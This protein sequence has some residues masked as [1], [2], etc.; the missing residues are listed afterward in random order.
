MHI[1]H[2]FTI[3]H[4]SQFLHNEIVDYT[5]IDCFSQNRDEIVLHFHKNEVSK[6]LVLNV[7]SVFPFYYLTANFS[8][9]HKNTATIF[10]D[11]FHLNVLSVRILEGERILIIHLENDH[12]VVLKLFGKLSNVLHYFNG[13]VL[14]IFRNSLDDDFGWQP[15]P[16]PN[17]QLFLSYLN[18]EELTFDE[19]L[20][21]PYW[22]KFFKN[23]ILTYREKG[24]SAIEIAIN[25]YEIFLNPRF[26]VSRNLEFQ[27]F[28]IHDSE[29]FIFDDLNEALN[30]FV[31]FFYID[32]QFKVKKNQIQKQIDSQIKNL[33]NKIRSNEISIQNLLNSRSYE[34]IAN[35]LMANL[36]LD[37]K[38]LDRYIF[39][40]FYL[41]GKIEI[42]LK[43]E[44]SLQQNAE[45]YYQKHK[46]RKK[47]LLS[48]E[49]LFSENQSKLN[50]LLQLKNE[51]DSITSLKTLD[52]WLKQYPQFLGQMNINSMVS[53]P[54]KEFIIQGFKIWVGKDAK[55]NDQLTLHYAH[56]NDIWLHAKDVSGS[57]V[58]IKTQN[59]K[60]IPKEIIVHAAE[61]AG[62]YSKNRNQN[63]IP[64]IY[65]E[66]KYVRKGKGL[67][68]GKV[69]VERENIV[70]VS[71]KSYEQIV[72]L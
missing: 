29:F 48:L 63:Y 45:L 42:S 46:K 67:P 23:Y 9:S 41:S 33:Q 49:V 8:K 57:H 12:Q 58:L 10:E 40:D 61:L 55:S 27:L 70:F 30:R 17:F 35:I 44:L 19:L 2:Y 1:F 15:H 3:H 28:P 24:Y 18:N 34:E 22:D 6:F 59:H 72:S 68:P 69:I 50:N 64:V 20:Q 11:I 52:K 53:L 62:Y 38:N 5:L 31:K 21:L 66:K 36:H 39:D 47:E 25:L 56:K 37:V 13:Q 43:K 71:P 65:T 4:F 32:Y 16:N 7:H 14:E 51:L 54:Y 26:Y 60:T